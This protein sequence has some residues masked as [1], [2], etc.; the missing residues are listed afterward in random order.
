[1]PESPESASAPRVTSFAPVYALGLCEAVHIEP[2]VELARADRNRACSVPTIPMSITSA[3]SSAMPRAY[4]R[5]HAGRRQPHVAPE[6]HGE[7]LDRRGL[8]IGEHAREAAADAVGELL[9]HLLGVDAPDVVGLED[10]GVHVV[11]GAP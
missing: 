9:V 7:L 10:G 2:A 4:S 3:P 11:T 6:P 8:E 5:R 1:M